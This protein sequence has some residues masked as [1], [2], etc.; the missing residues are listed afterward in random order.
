MIFYKIRLLILGY[1]LHGV[2]YILGLKLSPKISV[3]A[4]IEKGGLFLILDLSYRKGFGFPGGMVE[5]GESLE[6]ALARELKEETGLTI[7]KIKYITSKKDVQY[8]FPVLVVAYSVVAT[9]ELINSN[10]GVLH[11]KTKEEILNNCSYKNSKEAFM[12][13]LTLKNK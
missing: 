10:E 6:E 7:T 13:Y 11:Y 1:T 8:R 5:G 4:F 9:G 12:E 3:T 2:A